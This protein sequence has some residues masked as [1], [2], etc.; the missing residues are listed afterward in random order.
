MS[1][2]RRLAVLFDL[3]GTLVDSIELIVNSFQHAFASHSGPSPEEFT[4]GIGR[5]LAAQFAPYCES[6][7]QVQ[8]LI[9]KYREYQLA[10][11]DR[12]T[13]PYDGM[14]NAVVTLRDEGH[15][16]GV[17]TSK[18]EP[19]A[20]RALQ[21]VGFSEHFQVVIGSD[22]TARHKPDPEPVLLALDRLHMAAENAVFVGDSPYDVQAGR[23]AGVATVGVVWGAFARPRLEEAGAEH[24]VEHPSE[25]PGL[26]A[27]IAK[28]AVF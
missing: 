9:S 7:E 5:P 28:L 22:A 14:A 11:H 19:L 21:H 27:R 16:L 17:V 20:R 10:H 13:K 18:I 3:D 25:L 23:A 15:A 2:P 6:A 12:L 8:F 1:K 24:V 26:V 4:T